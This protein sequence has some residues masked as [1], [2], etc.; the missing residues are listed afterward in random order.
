MAD[1]KTIIEDVEEN[2]DTNKNNKEDKNKDKLKGKRKAPSKT[3][4]AQPD[5]NLDS[6]KKDNGL[7]EDKAKDKPL[8]W[9]PLSD[10]FYKET[11]LPGIPKG[12]LTLFRGFTNTG[13]ST[14]V[15][16][17]TIGC[18]K[19]GILPVII[20]TENAWNWEHAREMG[21]QFEDVLDENTGEVINYKGFFI[22]VNNDTLLTKYGNWNYQEAKKVKECRTEAAI[23][24]C[25]RYVDELLDLQANG[26]LNYELCFFWDSIGTLRAF[27]SIESK[28][29][30][31]MWAAGALER[32]FMAI[33]NHKIPSSKKE[34]KKYTNTFLGVQKIRKDSV[35]SGKPVIV[36][37]G[38]DCFFHAARLVVHMGGIL[39]HGTT[40]I[41]ATNNGNK[42]YY[43]T[44]SAIK[45]VKNH[46]NGVTWEGKMLSTAHGYV[47]VDNKD[48]YINKYR[49]FF[50][51]KLNILDE[52]AEIKL[53]EDDPTDDDIRDSLVS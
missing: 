51:E 38:G 26:K 15:Y 47:S 18:Q 27:Q 34:G 28:S 32:S 44:E 45:I 3:P 24:D 40:Q 20:D 35:S 25:A 43:A 19:L 41:Y 53:E 5:F 16:E 4:I 22:Y 8:D 1:K 30:N 48:K 9:I 12:F 39:T 7:N 11:G 6:F 31:N 52:N 36:H 23:E 49:K 29:N 33:L 42:F 46:V 2:D 10:D 13:K 21:V 14:A 17:G 37:K 50:L